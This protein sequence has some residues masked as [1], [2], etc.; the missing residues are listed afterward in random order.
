M[1]EVLIFGGTSEGRILAET[2]AAHG[3]RADISVATDYGAKLLPK[4]G[5]TVHIGR[6]HEREM[7]ELLIRRKVKIVIDATHPYAELV[8]GEIQSACQKAAIPYYRLIREQSTPVSGFCGTLDAVIEYLN[9]SDKT[10]LST[11]GSKELPRLTAVRDY[12]SRIRMRLLDSAGL[13]AY[14]QSLGYNTSHIIFGKG[15]FS[16]EENINHLRSSKAQ[17]LLTKD[18]GTIGGYPQKAEAARILR[19]EL[20]TVLRPKETGLTLSEIMEILL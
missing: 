3:I 16:V 10:I 1:T 5:I 9:G 17:I 8:T 4:Q 12:S 11:L 15:P 18:S 19:I 2:C 7:L 13:S 20:V 14:C 6:L